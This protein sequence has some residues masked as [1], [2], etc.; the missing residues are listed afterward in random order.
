MPFRSSH[1]PRRSYNFC[2]ILFFVEITCESLCRD[3]SS[4]Y[5]I[6]LRAIQD[7]LRDVG[8]GLS[9]LVLTTAIKLMKITAKFTFLIIYSTSGLFQASY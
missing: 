5:E 9:S 8:F 7:S 6:Y 2:V 3:K 1:R 4:C